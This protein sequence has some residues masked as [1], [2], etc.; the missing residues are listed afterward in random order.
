MTMVRRI[1]IAVIVPGLVLGL[2]GCGQKGELERPKTS[3]SHAV[4]TAYGRDAPQ[5]TA[6]L[7]KPPVQAVPGLSSE[8]RTKSEPREDDPFNLPP[9]E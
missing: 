1:L 2:G 5:T 8:L 4:P 3:K 9:K 7:M 6:A